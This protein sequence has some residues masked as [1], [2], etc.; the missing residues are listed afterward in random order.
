MCYSQKKK[1]CI[2]C[3]IDRPYKKYDASGRDGLS[4]ACTV[5]VAR[6]DIQGDIPS[7]HRIAL[8][9]QPIIPREH[10]PPLQSICFPTLP[11]WYSVLII[12]GD[13]VLEE[14]VYLVIQKKKNRPAPSH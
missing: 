1:N 13:I 8:F 10:D 11:F 4:F 9:K 7:F 3:T 12:Q 5:G 14:D 2:R 6:N